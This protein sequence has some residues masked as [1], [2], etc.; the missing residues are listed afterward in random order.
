MTCA[1]IAEALKRVLPNSEE[2]R[3]IAAAALKVRL[4]LGSIV[5][6]VAEFSCLL[7]R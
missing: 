5:R 1:E 3:L 4:P 6:A 7:W 2:Y